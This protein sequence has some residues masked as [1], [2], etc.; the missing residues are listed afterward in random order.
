MRP[1]AEIKVGIITL[2]AIVLVGAY[3]FYVRGY[4]AAR[5]TYRVCVTFESTRGIEPGDPVRMVGVR[6]GKVCLKN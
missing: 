1:G 5:A 6:I 4:I 3:L 2:I